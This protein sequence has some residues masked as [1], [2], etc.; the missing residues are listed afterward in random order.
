MST[1]TLEEVKRWCRVFHSND[2]TLL[3]ELIDQAEDEALR[4]LS[5]TQPPTLPLDY[6]PEYDSSSSEIPEDV[7][8]SDDPVAKSY[9]KAVCI[10]V[11]AYYEAPDADERDKMRRA[12]EV[13]LFPYR[14]GLG[15]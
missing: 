1:V 13:V 4:F 12:A 2:D 7:P 8:S 3:G 5:R 6:P 11:Q 15:V 14:S 10:L 9:V